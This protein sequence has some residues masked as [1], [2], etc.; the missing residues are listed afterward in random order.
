MTGHGR[1]FWLLAVSSFLLALFTAPASQLLN[2]FL[3]DEQ[4]FSALRITMFSLI[5]NTPGGI[6]LVVGGRL[7]DN[8]G[9]RLVGAVGVF[10]GTLLTVLMVLLGGWPM[11]GLSMAGAIV[12]AMVVPALGVY[13]PELFPTA[14]RGRANGIISILG[15]TGSV[16]GLATAGYLSDRWNG[17]GPALAVLAV[18]PLLMA[19]LVL[20][21]YPETAHLELEDI[22]PEDRLGPGPVP[23]AAPAARTTPVD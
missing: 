5:T 7:A 12:G 16:I 3:R 23:S 10:G 8:R 18:G 6:G 17:L 9:R 1:R 4:G 11:W 22:N 14:L 20:A 21:A 19:G 15:V 13:G 2:E